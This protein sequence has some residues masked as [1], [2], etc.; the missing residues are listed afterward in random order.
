MIDLRRPTVYA[1]IY[2]VLKNND[3]EYGDKKHMKDWIFF[4][5]SEL[6]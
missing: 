4:N 1:Y 3:H 5:V 6:N 2:L